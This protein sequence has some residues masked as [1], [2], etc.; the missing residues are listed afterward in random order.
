M[1]SIEELKLANDKYAIYLSLELI[2]VDN[3]L[4]RHSQFS[5]FNR[6]LYP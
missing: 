1:K 5:K 6:I 4:L 2:L 3:A